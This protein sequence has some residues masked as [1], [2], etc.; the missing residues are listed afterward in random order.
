MK[1]FRTYQLAKQLYQLS[2]TLKLPAYLRGQ[3][4][5]ASSSVVLNLAEGR[6]KRTM[7]DQ[8]KF[9]DISFGS[10]REVQAIF[11]LSNAPQNAHQLAD[12]TA[13]HL[14]KLLKNLH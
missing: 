11:D 13:A 2:C 12:Q 5:R 9:F 3:L 8:R 4:L 7:A 14:Y 1:N 10:I 6:G